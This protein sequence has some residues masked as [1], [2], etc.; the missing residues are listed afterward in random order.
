MYHVVQKIHH[1]ICNPFQA[2][3]SFRLFIVHVAHAYEIA[4]CDKYERIT[5]A[6]GD[7]GISWEIVCSME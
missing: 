7:L 4:S 6:F 2:A 1:I 5:E 3:E